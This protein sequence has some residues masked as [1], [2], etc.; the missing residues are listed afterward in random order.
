[1]D[2]IL[3]DSISHLRSI[4]LYDSLAQ[5]GEGKELEMIFTH[6]HRQSPTQEVKGFEKLL[7]M[8]EENSN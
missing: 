2:N 3:A 5:E 7:T 1:M 8:L 6:R 4:H